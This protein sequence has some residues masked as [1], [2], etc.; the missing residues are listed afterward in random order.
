MMTIAQS[1]RLRNNLA[2]A[3][4]LAT[5]VV[6]TLTK[7]VAIENW[8]S[9]PE[10]NGA[11]LPLVVKN[12]CVLHNLL[13]EVDDVSPEQNRNSFGHS[14]LFARVE[15][16]ENVP[17]RMSAAKE[18]LR[19]MV[20]KQMEAV[21][22]P[23]LESEMSEDHALGVCEM[24]TAM[25]LWPAV[26]RQNRER[27]IELL[28]SGVR[29]VFVSAIQS[30][31]LLNDSA[32]Q[33]LST[34]AVTASCSR[35]EKLSLIGLSDSCRLPAYMQILNGVTAQIS[36]FVGRASQRWALLV[37]TSGVHCEQ[38][39]PADEG[40]E[41]LWSMIRKHLFALFSAA[42]GT[43]ALFIEARAQPVCV[44]SNARDL[45]LLL[46]AAQN[47][48][49]DMVAQ[50]SRV[51]ETVGGLGD[52]WSCLCGKSLK[53]AM[54]RLGKE[55]VRS[56]H[57]RN[58]E[59]IRLTVEG[60]DW[61]PHDSDADFQSRVCAVF[62][63]DNDS[64]T[65]LKSLTV[66]T[67]FSDANRSAHTAPCSSPE[68]EAAVQ[69]HGGQSSSSDPSVVGDGDTKKPFLLPNVDGPLD[70]RVISISL[71]MLLES[72]SDYDDYLGRFPFLA[73][74]I[75]GEVYDLLKLYISQCAALLL[76]AMAVENGTLAAITVQHMAVASQ[77]LALLYDGIP[78]IQKRWEK[79]VDVEK[80]SPSTPADMA[81]VRQDCKTYRFEF[82]AKMAS[83]VKEKVDEV[84]VVS[85]AQWQANG[86]EWVMTML[87]E[88]AR[89]MRTLKPLLPPS[90]CRGVVVP[91]LGT[92]A[93]MIRAVT[94]SP[95]VDEGQ[96]ETIRS[97]VLV[98]KANLE[99][100]G[101]DVLRCVALYV[102]PVDAMNEL[103]EPC[104]TDEA[105]VEW[106]FGDV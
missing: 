81:R 44:P 91:L 85:G 23:H 38:S 79:V 16:L 6:E 53:A 58:I 98:F 61:G 32:V 29:D 65:Q 64:V 92:F 88:T 41:S 35:D 15:M 30:S 100:F 105:V 22:M 63:S 97:D 76:G 90:D 84:G 36:D 78:L 83:L 54:T 70:G 27:L 103:Q 94:M 11:E 73:F 71:Q 56:H 19:T 77:N 18:S 45:Q 68:A 106:F 60:E 7:M 62:R 49:Q 59:K 43:T 9:L 4:D 47:F 13:F 69:P 39:E 25:N 12:Y 21:L 75:M 66:F 72:L 5:G 96:R 99:K 52:P 89:L 104:A 10:R 67:D 2:A 8:I 20:M 31:G 26:L 1:Y 34:T 37:V 87:R 86:S 40:E 101:F 82:F 46:T 33:S 102:S 17:E 51:A 74:D 14:G 55:H 93:R 24:V 48:M 42:E 57:A 80:I 50:F 3:R 28:W 95:D